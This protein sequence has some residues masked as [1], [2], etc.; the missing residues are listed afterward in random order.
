MHLGKIDLG[1]SPQSVNGISR[2]VVHQ[3]ERVTAV[4]RHGIIFAVSLG[5]PRICAYRHILCPNAD[6]SSVEPIPNFSSR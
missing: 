3:L 6:R 5:R 1:E 4:F 2:L